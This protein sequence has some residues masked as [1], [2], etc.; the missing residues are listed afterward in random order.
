MN[1]LN[2]IDG[3]VFLTY[4]AVVAAYGW[5]VYRRKKRAPKPPAPTYF[6]PKA[7]LPGGP[8]ARR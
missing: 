5:I 7:P 6:W 1:Q 8:L 4:F 2:L 3:V